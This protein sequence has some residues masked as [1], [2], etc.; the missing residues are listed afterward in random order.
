MFYKIKNNIYF[1][2]FLFLISMLIRGLFFLEFLVKDE[3]FFVCTDSAEYQGIALNIFHGNGIKNHNDVLNF[4]RLPGYPI[5]LS[6]CYKI[7]DIKI[8]KALWLQIILSLFIPILVF[9][10]SLTFF[11]LNIFLAKIVSVWATFHIGFLLHS[12]MI[13][14]DS[15]FVIFFLLFLILF[16]SS[17]NLFFCKEGFLFLSKRRIFCAGI[18]LGISSLIRPVGHYCMIISLLLFLFSNF[19]F[20]QKLKG[21][22]ILFS[23]WFVIVFWWILRNF[24][25]TGFLFF[26][27]LPGIHFLIYSAAY[28]DMEVNKCSYSDSKRKL[29]KKW[30]CEILKKQDKYGRKLT[31][32]ESCYLAENIS[33]DYIKKNISIFLKHSFLHMFKTCVWPYSLTLLFWDSGRD[34]SYYKIMS[35][36][37]RVKRFLFP[38]TSSWKV[39]FIIYFELLFLLLLNFGFIGFVI[40][41]FFNKEFFCVLS[42]VFPFMFLFIFVTLAYGIARL[43]LS[44]EPF[45][46]ILAFKFW[47]LILKRFFKSEISN[48]KYIKLK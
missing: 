6:L 19:D 10:L 1:C 3:N 38:T 39:L 25:L 17:F 44:I 43:R 23:G 7:F 40:V 37:D 32:I 48:E 12:G 2:I 29:I 13:Q 14:S 27:T 46:A 15:I 28:I 47:V 42:K 4:R 11:P 34:S 16:F 41:S 22:I 33:F 45:Q 9:C 21:T 31:D 26:H 20:F 18:F 30:N 24:L 8:K 5:F 35:F 36:F